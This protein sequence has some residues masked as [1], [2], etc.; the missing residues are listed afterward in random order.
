MLLGRLKIE[1]RPLSPK[2][3]ERSKLLYLQ[4]ESNNFP[5]KCSIFV[6]TYFFSFLTHAKKSFK[7][8]CTHNT[9][10]LKVFRKR[11][12]EQRDNYPNPFSRERG[13]EKSHPCIQG[14]F[15]SFL[16]PWHWIPQKCVSSTTLYAGVA[17]CRAN[18]LPR[19]FCHLYVGNPSKH[20]LQ[21]INSEWQASRKNMI[22]QRR[23]P[24]WWK[25]VPILRLHIIWNKTYFYFMQQAFSSGKWCARNISRF[26]NV[27]KLE[28]K[29]KREIFHGQ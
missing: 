9:Q 23:T 24:F 18:Y 8:V 15:S 16:C 13:R 27:E 26:E 19:I 21:V 7:K 3:S 4:G 11:R 12:L 2:W 14:F 10:D 29:A 25:S 28:I 17:S 20:S 22:R 6:K 1:P 5:Q